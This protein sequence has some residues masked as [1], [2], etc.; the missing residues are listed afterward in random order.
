[1]LTAN[2]PVLQSESKGREGNKEKPQSHRWDEEATVQHQMEHRQAEHWQEKH[3]NL[4]VAFKLVRNLLG[5]EHYQTH[6][7][8]KLLLW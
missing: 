6:I 2:P 8:V 3:Q 4:F 7:L 5:N 1:M